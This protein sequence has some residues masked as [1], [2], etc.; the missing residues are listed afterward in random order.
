MRVGNLGFA[1]GVFLL[2]FGQAAFAKPVGFSM[3]TLPKGK[4]VTL[5]RPAVTYVALNDKVVVS[6]TD[7]P[8]TVKL[9]SVNINDGAA[10]PFRIAIY[11]KKAAAIKRITLTRTDGI[12][13]R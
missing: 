12:I 11:D 1:V 9:S 4:D 13:P 8:Q 6:A 3:S 5:P 2:I 10:I 7:M